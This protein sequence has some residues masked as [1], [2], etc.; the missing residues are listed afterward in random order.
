MAT[1][2]KRNPA[3]VVSRITADLRR[4]GTKTK[5]DKATASTSEARAVRAA[6]RQLDGQ[7]KEL[8]DAIHTWGWFPKRK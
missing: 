2:R 8:R 4:L 3:K 7:V 5:H 6:I 1:T